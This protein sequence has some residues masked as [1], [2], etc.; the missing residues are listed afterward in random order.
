MA[1]ADSTYEVVVTTTTERR[2]RVRAGAS[3]EAAFQFGTVLADKDAE[4]F[5]ETVVSTKRSA[6]KNL[7]PDTPA[8]KPAQVAEEPRRPIVDRPQA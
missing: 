5:S 7:G 4:P 3:H 2:F 8:E 6:P 1:K